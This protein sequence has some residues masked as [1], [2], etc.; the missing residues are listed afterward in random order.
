MLGWALV[1]F[2]LAL[3]AAAFDFGGLAG[4]A[5]SIAQILFVIFLALTMLT[6]FGFEIVLQF[7]DVSSTFDPTARESLRLHLYFAV[8]SAILLPLMY[9][10]GW[11]GRKRLHL[12]LAAIFA[13]LWVGTFVTGEKLKRSRAKST[14][15]FM[16][17]ADSGSTIPARSNSK[18]TTRSLGSC[19]STM[20]TPAPSACGVPPGMIKVSPGFTLIRSKHDSI[21]AMFWVTMYSRSCWRVG[22]R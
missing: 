1:F 3:V 21:A 16:K 2:V 10:S 7:V 22:G 6:V 12:V 13:T 11:S 14:S 20:N 9:L 4:V 17:R 15:R 5:A 19:I 18:R 8:P